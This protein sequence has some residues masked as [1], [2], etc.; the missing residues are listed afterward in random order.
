MSP[1]RI[2]PQVRQTHM[3]NETGEEEISNILVPSP[4]LSWILGVLSGAGN[5]RYNGIYLESTRNPELLKE[6]S[7]VGQRL[8]GKQPHIAPDKIHFFSSQIA[9]EIGDL[10]NS[11]WVETIQSRHKWILNNSNFIWKFIEGLFDTRAHLKTKPKYNGYTLRFRTNKFTNA[12]FIK[13]LLLAASLQKPTIFPDEEQPKETEYT[14]SM[15]NI[16][17]LKVIADNINPKSPD[18]QDQLKSIKEEP[19]PSPITETDLYAEWVRLGRISSSYKLIKLYREGQTK[20]SRSSYDRILGEGSFRDAISRLKKLEELIGKKSETSSLP[21]SPPQEQ[22]VFVAGADGE[23]GVDGKISYTNAPSTRKE[24][25][26]DVEPA[27]DR[28]EGPLVF[29][30]G[31]EVKDLPKI[32]KNLLELFILKS[33][34]QGAKVTLGDLKRVYANATNGSSATEEA[35]VRRLGLLQEKINDIGAPYKIVN[36]TSRKARE[37]GEEAAFA[38]VVISQKSPSPSGKDSAEEPR[39]KQP[40]QPESLEMQTIRGQLTQKAITDILSAIKD[41]KSENRN[42]RVILGRAL[43]SGV[44]LPDVFRQDIIDDKTLEKSFLGDLEKIIGYVWTHDKFP[45]NAYGDRLK[46]IEGIVNDLRKQDY[47]I[48]SLVRRVRSHFVTTHIS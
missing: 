34:E 36:Q 30:D 25:S 6:F 41:G 39:R 19:S 7:A 29:P 28:K 16:E 22:D 15:Y 14:V 17:D 26:A 20:Y 10:R 9:R 3:G 32:E 18:K 37:K 24:I 38:L 43:P 40:S 35:I 46:K 47:T 11:T 13:K 1:E 21:P 12:E 8:F 33:K 5:V 44:K 48:E 2:W 27:K 23:V 4:E 42:I 45:K 31:T